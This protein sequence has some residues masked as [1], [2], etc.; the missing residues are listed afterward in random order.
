LEHKKESASVYMIVTKVLQFYAF[1]AL[2]IKH[3]WAIHTCIWY[4]CMWT[5][6][7]R[8]HPKNGASASMDLR[9]VRKHSLTLREMQDAQEYTQTQ[10]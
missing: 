7:W 5:L 10:T 9:R 3:W 8:A 2:L 6:S 1:Q 4:R